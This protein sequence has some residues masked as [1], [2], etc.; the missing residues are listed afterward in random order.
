MEKS[1]IIATRGA[2][3]TFEITFWRKVKTIT[4]Y[5]TL[6]TKITDMLVDSKLEL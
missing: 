5:E 1:K 3:E 4:I 6:P 2:D